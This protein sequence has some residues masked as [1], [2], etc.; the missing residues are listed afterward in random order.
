MTS[1]RRG[2]IPFV[3]VMNNQISKEIEDKLQGDAIYSSER[4]QDPRVLNA[5]SPNFY[6]V[7]K[8]DFNSPN[9]YNLSIFKPFDRTRLRTFLPVSTAAEYKKEIL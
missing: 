8:N 1:H 7:R 5:A 6:F 9:L 4:A 2:A 3:E